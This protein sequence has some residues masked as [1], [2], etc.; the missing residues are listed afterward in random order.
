MTV[1][2][3]VPGYPPAMDEPRPDREAADKVVA[4]PGRCPF[5]A[6]ADQAWVSA[7]SASE[8][9]CQAVRPSASLSEQKQRRLCL[10]ADHGTC[11]TYVAAIEAREARAPTSESAVGWEWVRT[12]PVVD[13]RL[14]RGSTLLAVV[15]DRRTR[16]VV[17]AIALVAALGALGFSNLGSGGGTAIPGPTATA[18]PL[19]SVS[20]SP[21]VVASEP[22][23]ATA[24]PESS[25]EPTPAPTSV[26][27]RTPSPTAAPTAKPSARASYTVKSGDTL[28]G[29][30]RQF[31]ISTTA[32]KNFNGLTTNVIHVGQVLLIP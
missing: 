27:T 12:T 20:T 3:G 28:Y 6:S 32:L 11:A 24:S 7:T 2:N 21:P 22:P 17:P 5:L 19:P 16:Q 4:A 14:G 31:G 18:S 8:H 25:P 29:I 1:S 30:A 15:G 9:R 23:V 10:T 13:P 26:P